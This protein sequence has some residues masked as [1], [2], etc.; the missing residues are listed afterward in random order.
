MEIL[1]KDIRKKQ[2]LHPKDHEKMQELEAPD[3]AEVGE[4]EWD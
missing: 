4:L 2:M 3:I 1:A